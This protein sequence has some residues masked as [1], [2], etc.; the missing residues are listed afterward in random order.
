MLR[1]TDIEVGAAYANSLA[2]IQ[3][4]RLAFYAFM[5]QGATVM[6]PDVYRQ[7]T[8]IYM[9]RYMALGRLFRFA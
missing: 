8:Y 9:Y 7:Y 5:R 4:T 1:S 6:T 2:N 3:L